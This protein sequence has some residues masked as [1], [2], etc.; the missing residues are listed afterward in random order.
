MKAKKRKTRSPTAEKGGMPRWNL[1]TAKARF[2]ELVRKAQEGPQCV[3]VHGKEA[4][5]LLSGEDYAR[6]RARGEQA[7]LRDL[8]VNSPLR[9]LE[10]GEPGIESPVR[11]VEL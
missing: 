8:L 2:S 7:T 6:L 3:T 9:D 11:E 1:E 5:V 4:A 10:F